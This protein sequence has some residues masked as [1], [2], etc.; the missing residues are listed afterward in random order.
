MISNRRYYDFWGIPGMV[1][2]IVTTSTARIKNIIDL[3][4]ERR[5]PAFASR[6]LLTSYPTFAGENWLVPPTILTDILK[7]WETVDKPF[8]ICRP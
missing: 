8:D 7:P 3:L 6:F 5:D 2:L 4:K 1:V